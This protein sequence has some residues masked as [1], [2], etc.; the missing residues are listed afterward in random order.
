MLLYGASCLLVSFTTSYCNQPCIIALLLR[1]RTSDDSSVS[2]SLS[3]SR[4]TVTSL[5]S[6]TTIEVTQACGS[7][8]GLMMHSCAR[9]ENMEPHHAPGLFPERPAITIDARSSLSVFSDALSLDLGAGPVDGWS[10]H[11]GAPP[12]LRDTLDRA[13]HR[14]CARTSLLCVPFEPSLLTNRKQGVEAPRWCRNRPSLP[15]L[16]ILHQSCWNTAFGIDASETITVPEQQ[17]FCNRALCA[18]KFSR[19]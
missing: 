6:A 16:M 13:S 18:T 10:P 12:P 2:R 17:K 1:W 9:L 3:A 4:P 7:P 11:T 14:L 8:G 5:S 19:S 15:E